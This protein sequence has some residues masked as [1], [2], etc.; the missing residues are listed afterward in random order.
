MNIIDLKNENLLNDIKKCIIK[1][2][3]VIK[4]EKCLQQSSWSQFSSAHLSTDPPLWFWIV[5]PVIKLR[6]AIF[7]NWH[8][9]PWQTFTLLQGLSCCSVSDELSMLSCLRGLFFKIKKSLF[10]NHCFYPTTCEQSLLD[11]MKTIHMGPARKIC[12]LWGRSGCLFLKAIKYD[13]WKKPCYLCQHRHFTWWFHIK[14]GYFRWLKGIVLSL[15][16]YQ[17]CFN[18]SCIIN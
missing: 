12:F 17:T 6:E 8:F 11:T 14:M 7:Q 13:N 16:D 15:Y 3:N 5:I 2:Q 1:Q 9:A 10:M 18:F 4:K